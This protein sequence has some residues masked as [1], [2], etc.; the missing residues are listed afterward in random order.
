MS[1]LIPSFLACV[2]RRALRV[3]V[4]SLS[5]R[6]SK[7]RSTRLT[8]RG[9]FLRQAF[10]SARDRRKRRD[11]W[12][13]GVRRW[14]WGK[15]RG[16][17]RSGGKRSEERDWRWSRADERT[18]R[19]TR[20]KWREGAKVLCGGGLWVCSIIRDVEW[21]W[22]CAVFMVVMSTHSITSQK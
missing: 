21:R 6:G 22:T 9:H 3:C 8:A 15:W 14:H 11:V 2:V 19:Q 18:R 10:I 4:C 7:V 13:K 20:E 1:Y 16:G 12:M 17:R 5:R